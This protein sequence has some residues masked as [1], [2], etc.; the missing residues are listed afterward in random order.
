MAELA[1]AQMA[2]AQGNNTIYGEYTKYASNR[3]IYF[4]SI[5][6]QGFYPDYP[7]QREFYASWLMPLIFMNKDNT[8]KFQELVSPP[9]S[10]LNSG[11]Q[12]DYPN[13]WAPLVWALL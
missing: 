1:I 3:K 4:N 9:T 2:L 10:F 7:E 11:Q 12:W 8:Y 6:Q 13:V 5:E